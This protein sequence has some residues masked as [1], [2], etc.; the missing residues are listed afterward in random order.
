[1]EQILVSPLRSAELFAAKIIPTVVRIL[2]F[3]SMAL[4]GVVQGVFHTP[5]RGSFLLF[6]S[7]SVL[8]IA[9]VA[10]LGLA[11]PFQHYGLLQERDLTPFHFL[12][13]DMRP[14]HALWNAPGSWGLEMTLGYQNTWAMSSNV[15]DYLQS[16]PKR[17]SL[18]PEEVRAIRAL[19]GESYLVDFELGTLD[20]VFHRRLSSQW[21]VLA[22]FSGVSYAGGFLDGSIEQFHK[23]FGFGS[24]GR[25]AVRRNDVN[26][27]LTLKGK[28]SALLG[29][30]PSGGL[31]DPT[32]G[33]R[34]SLLPSAGPWNLVLESSVKMPVR[35]QREFLSTGHFDTGLQATLQR[36]LG[37]HAFYLSAAA[38]HTRGLDLA[39]EESKIIPTI[40]AGY[41][42]VFDKRTNLIIQSYASRST[43]S[44]Q[45]T[46]LK[47][48]RGGKYQL[49]LGLRHRAG[50]SLWTVALT[51][52]VVHLNNTPDVGFQ[53]GWIYSPAFLR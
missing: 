37:R 12:R 39:G 6:R 23:A 11:N 52:N 20:F 33:L 26:V 49:S 28:R 48:L 2:L 22:S 43:F 46:D 9:S 14:A 41:E 45:D 36:F 19:P 4:F 5:L 16:L 34:Y 32:V 51:E 13:L 29:T 44:R 53:L 8:Y 15:R 47:E 17:S 38:V 21:S 31:L 18:G 1:M 35:G 27:I 50:P 42:Y 24:F 7:V 25:Y 40:I 3:S 30:P 10:S